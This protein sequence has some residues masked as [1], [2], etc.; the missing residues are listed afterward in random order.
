VVVLDSLSIKLMVGADSSLFLS[1]GGLPTNSRDIFTG[2][3]IMGSHSSNE[4]F[5]HVLGSNFT[6]SKFG[7][8]ANP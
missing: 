3:R 4:S 1:N 7:M 6:V 2:T 8:S 5:L